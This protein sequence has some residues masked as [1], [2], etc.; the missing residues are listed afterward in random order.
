MRVRVP[1]FPPSMVPW[2][3]LEWTSACHAEDRGF[4]SL[5]S[6]HL[7]NTRSCRLAVGHPVLNRT[8]RVRTP[9]GAPS[10]KVRELPRAFVIPVEEVVLSMARWTQDLQVREGVVVAIAILV[11][12]MKDIGDPL[13][14]AL[15][16][17]MREVSECQRPVRI[18]SFTCS[19]VD[20]LDRLDPADPLSSILVGATAKQEAAFRA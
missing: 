11:V 19:V 2:S 12:D 14:S 9:L 7:N 17:P 8:A 20:G 18:M 6:R 16:T 15:P 10:H 4:K 3:S 1:S 13:V 5:R